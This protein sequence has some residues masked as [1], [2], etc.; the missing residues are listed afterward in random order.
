MIVSQVR[1]A[2]DDIPRMLIMQQ[3]KSIYAV[4]VTRRKRSEV[5]KS[6]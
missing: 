1:M 5:F 3:S 6:N 2:I 4:M